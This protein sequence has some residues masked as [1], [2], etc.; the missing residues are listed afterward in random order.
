MIKKLLIGLASLL[1]RLATL[2]GFTLSEQAYVAIT[3]DLSKTRGKAL[4]ELSTLLQPPQMGDFEWKKAVAAHLSTIRVLHDK[5]MELAPPRS[6]AHI[7]LKS[8][9]A[10]KHINNYTDLL[11]QGIGKQDPSLLEQASQEIQV[12]TQLINE[13]AQLMLEFREARQ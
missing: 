10:W 8:I 5:A 11:A 7:H 9:Q 12:G 2:V 3:L 4:T 13:A 1:F 6:M